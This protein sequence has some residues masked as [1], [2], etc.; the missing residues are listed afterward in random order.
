MAADA[1]DGDRVL[2]LRRDGLEE[3]RKRYESKRE[4]EGFYVPV[5]LHW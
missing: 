3:E 5:F 4:M 1:A 2:R